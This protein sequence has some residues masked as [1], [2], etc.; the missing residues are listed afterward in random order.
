MAET[1][2]ILEDKFA[3]GAANGY[4]NVLS[5]FLAI[6]CFGNLT[7]REFFPFVTNF[8][9]LDFFFKFKTNVIGP[10]QNFL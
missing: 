10:G 8:E 7:A 4:S 1:A 2:L 6:G 9:I 3:S 5:K